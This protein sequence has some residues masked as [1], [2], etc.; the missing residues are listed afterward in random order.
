MLGAYDYRSMPYIE[1][2]F[3]RKQLRHFSWILSGL[4]ISVF[5]HIAPAFCIIEEK[6][7]YKL[8]CN[9]ASWNATLKQVLDAL[10]S[11]WP[12]K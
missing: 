12:T 11:I 10:K 5:L 9:N 6:N 8:H 1:E 2:K 4:K 7:T 3:D